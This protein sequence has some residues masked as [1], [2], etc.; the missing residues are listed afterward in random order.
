MIEDFLRVQELPNGA[1]LMQPEFR[2]KE[3]LEGRR[4]NEIF[5][6]EKMLEAGELLNQRKEYFPD[7]LEAVIGRMK[8]LIKQTEEASENPNI[9][10]HLR[11]CAFFI[12]NQASIY[13]HPAVGRI[14][15][16]AFRHLEAN[17]KNF[18]VS[19]IARLTSQIEFIAGN[20]TAEITVDQVAE[21]RKLTEMI[22]KEAEQAN[23]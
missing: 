20:G 6:S 22:M 7:E 21:L 17:G 3:R 23:Y 13:G 12:R 19:L 5:S 9:W 18:S 10:K 2:L 14:G 15:D 1:K 16:L 8:A 11:E 4:I